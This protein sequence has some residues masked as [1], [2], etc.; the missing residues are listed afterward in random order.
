MSK[1]RKVSLLITVVALLALTGIA[2]HWL[3]HPNQAVIV[4]LS[5]LDLQ[6]VTLALTPLD[7]EAAP[8][9]RSFQLIR[10]GES[11]TVAH[12]FNDFAARLQFIDADGTPRRHESPSIDLWRGEEW[13]FTIGP[14]GHVEE[15]YRYHG[16]RPQPPPE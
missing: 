16:R 15:T 12:A 1:T 10:A 7:T 8:V 5:G 13:V 2:A 3:R 4:N 11:R 9:V 14:D 6:Q